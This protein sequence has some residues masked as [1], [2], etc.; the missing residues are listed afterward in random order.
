[1]QKQILVIAALLAL[2]A[3]QAQPE[4]APRVTSTMD[5]EK[6]ST[7]TTVRINVVDETAPADEDI[8]F[9]GNKKG[10]LLTED[11]FVP[12]T[13]ELGV[14]AELIIYN[15]LDGMAKLYSSDTSGEDCLMIGNFD[16]TA[17]DQKSFTFEEPLNCTILNQL[18]PEQNFKLTVN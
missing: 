6:A 1:M 17:N 10:V 16:I 14:D 4:E 5:Q 11:G 8:V 9:N 2:T 15:G 18:E 7:S 13:I 3:C 12:K